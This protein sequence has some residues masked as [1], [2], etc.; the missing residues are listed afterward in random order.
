MTDLTP[1]TLSAASGNDKRDRASA[2][3]WGIPQRSRESRLAKYHLSQHDIEILR[4]LASKMMEIA[5]S[6]VNSE[7]KKDWYDHDSR[8][9]SR[10]MILA[11][12]FDVRDE[13]APLPRSVIKCE[14][15]WAKGIEAQMRLEIYQFEVLKDDHVVEPFFNVNWHL[16]I[17]DLGVEIIQ[18]IANND[19]NM[20]VRNWEPPLRDLNKDFSQLHPFTF[21]VD[22]MTTLAEKNCL[23]SAIGDILPIRIRGRGWWSMGLTLDVAMLIG[24]ENLMTS[25]ITNTEGLHRLLS[26]LR[27]NYLAFAE[28]MEKEGLLTLNNENDS[29]GS[30]GLVYTHDLPQSGKKPNDPVQ[31]KDLWIFLDSQETVGVGPKRFEEVVFPYQ[32]SIAQRFGKCYYGCCEPLHSRWNVIKRIPNLARVSVSPWAD[33]YF[34]GQALGKDYVFSRKPHPI[35]VSTDFFDEEAIRVDI[36]KTLDAAKGCRLEIIMKDIHTL[37]NEPNRI[38]RWVEIAREEVSKIS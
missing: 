2:T 23:E 36:R 27:D 15:S 30:G 17:S 38:A 16:N 31:M 22:R 21:S 4:Q 14:N 26:F 35:L 33:Q 10:P 5:H 1:R 24:L 11:E 32:L 7:R 3:I 28:W 29:F 9:S 34:F 8:A 13:N 25:L 6:R 19:G 20:A 12:V 37:Y 18:H